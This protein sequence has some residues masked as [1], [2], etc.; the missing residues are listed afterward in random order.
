MFRGW[1]EVG[2]LMDS[3]EQVVA[4]IL[5]AKGF[6][7]RTSVKVNL[8]KAEKVKIERGSSPRWELDVVAFNARDNVLNVVECKSYLDSPGVQTAGFVVGTKAAAR[9]KLFNDAKLRE[10]IF[11]RLA[12]DFVSSGLCRPGPTVRL[13]LACGNI[14]KR[15]RPEIERRFEE[16]GWILW[17]ERWLREELKKLGQKESAYENQI[18][19]VVAK[20]I[21]RGGVDGSSE[22]RVASADQDTSATKAN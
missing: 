17:D 3:F 16:E 1:I 13:C 10:T 9:F 5:W 8:T 11:T 7:V 18:A 21:I 14:Q 19:S 22:A 6:W 4:E 15:S 2:I 20:L 12:T